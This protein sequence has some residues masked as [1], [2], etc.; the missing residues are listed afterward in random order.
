MNNF[1]K[2]SL[3]E[4]ELLENFFKSKGITDYN[5]TD[6]AGYER[7][8]AVFKTLDTNY[9][10]EVKV[11]NCT[12]RAFK[13]TLIEQ[14]K[15]AYLREKATEL[16]AVPLLIVFFTDDKAL[17]KNLRN[18]GGCTFDQRYCNRTTAADTGKKIKDVIL[19]PITKE[20]L[21]EV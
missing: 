19:I 21:R 11:R 8:D 1:R 14:S 16:N 9:I 4:R 10:V 5:F 3:K 18:L 12:S 20:N 15:V 7:H 2:S 13:D 6:E 17:V